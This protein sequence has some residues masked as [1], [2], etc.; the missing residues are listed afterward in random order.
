VVNK[1]VTRTELSAGVLIGR[2]HHQLVVGEHTA[3]EIRT[4]LRNIAKRQVDKANR[5]PAVDLALLSGPERYH[6][7]GG[8][9][10]S[11]VEEAL[12]NSLP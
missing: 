3:G 1:N 8:V 4:R 2:Y 10:A 6:N 5:E 11:M 9:V 12:A 7:A